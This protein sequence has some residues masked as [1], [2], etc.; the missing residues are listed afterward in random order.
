MSDVEF[1]AVDLETTGFSFRKDH[2]FEIACCGISGKRFHMFIKRTIPKKVQAITHIGQ[3]QVDQEGKSAAVVWRSLCVYMESFDKPIIL[4]GHNIFQFDLPFI[5]QLGQSQQGLH[6]FRFFKAIDTLRLVRTRKDL[7]AKASL[8]VVYEAICNARIRNAHQ[9]DADAQANLDLFMH[10]RFQ[11]IF[12]SCIR[13]GFT[14]QQC[15]QNYYERLIRLN[16]WSVPSNTSNYFP[17]VKSSSHVYC[18]ICSKIVSAYWLHTHTTP[19][20]GVVIQQPHPIA[21]RPSSSVC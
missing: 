19:N 16:K 2:I 18:H 11:T 3:H 9:A 21:F 17:V 15:V 4:V 1:V 13:T 8:G 6:T 14:Y 20:P 12:P 10:E 5:F 7:F